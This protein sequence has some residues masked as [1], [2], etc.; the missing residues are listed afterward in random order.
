MAH[1]LRSLSVLFLFYR[2]EPSAAV[3]IRGWTRF[4]GGATLLERFSSDRIGSDRFT[5]S[6]V[7]DTSSRKASALGAWPGAG[8]RRLSWLDLA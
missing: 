1:Y 4:L 6:H 2:S 5:F 3:L 8:R 7:A